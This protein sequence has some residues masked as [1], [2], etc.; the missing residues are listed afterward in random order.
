[1]SD[2]VNE[3]NEMKDLLV[4]TANNKRDAIQKQILIA[5]F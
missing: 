1:V 4:W 5:V 3:K 2:K